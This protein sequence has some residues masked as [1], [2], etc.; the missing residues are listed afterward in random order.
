MPRANRYFLPGNTYHLTHRCH[1]RQLLLRFAID[2]DAYRHILYESLQRSPVYLL[3]Y[4]ITSNHVHLLARSE[5]PESISSWMQRTEG[6]FAQHYNRRK[7]RSGAFWEG[8]YHSTLI[9]GGEHLWRCMSYIE[10][11]MVRAG[12]VSHPR[13][14]PWCSYQEWL[15]Q[16]QRYRLLD[17]GRALEFF[18][19]QDLDG[20]RQ[21]YEQR[22][23]ESVERGELAR[24]GQWTESVAVGGA[25]FVRQVAQAID[26]R[27]RFE[28]HESFSGAWALR[29][30]GLPTYLDQ[31]LGAKNSLQGP[32][33]GVYFQ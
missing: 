30:E 19:G 6:E 4:C 1:N 8:R 26:H 21:Y 13:L 7:R 29:E 23:Q 11:N 22:I 3:A 24:E 17:L 28:C 15:G 16:R 14:W 25:A 9:D 18:G 5:D 10:L 12:V 2:R 33:E 32:G 27:R 20:F 31:R